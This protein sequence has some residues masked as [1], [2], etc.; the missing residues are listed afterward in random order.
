MFRSQGIRHCYPTHHTSWPI[1][2][3]A[4][5]SLVQRHFHIL[6]C[7]SRPDERIS[8]TT[9]N[10]ILQKRPPAKGIRVRDCRS[11][12]FDFQRRRTRQRSQ[13]RILF[14]GQASLMCPQ[15]LDEEHGQLS[16]SQDSES[17]GEE[18]AAQTTVPPPL[19]DLSSS[20]SQSSDE[21]QEP[22]QSKRPHLVDLASMQS[23]LKITDLAAT[24][25]DKIITISS[26]SEGKEKAKRHHTIQEALRSAN[27]RPS[28]QAPA[29]SQ[30]HQVLLYT[31]ALAGEAWSASGSQ[32]LYEGRRA[33]SL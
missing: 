15:S 33:N 17:S 26:C 21:E 14:R 31:H 20:D 2:F 19:I 9:C 16:S 6:H 23:S 10:G 18:Q 13:L 30:R 24:P 29:I 8:N 7:R 11:I 3:S 27:G 12:R 1:T 28:T 4:C 5:V 25:A 22:G 32:Y